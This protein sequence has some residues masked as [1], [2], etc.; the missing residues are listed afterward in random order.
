VS[1]AQ[2]GG[3]E[4]HEFVARA[5]NIGKATEAQGSKRERSERAASQVSACDR[6]N[7]RLRAARRVCTS[8][9]GR[10]CRLTAALT[11]A[12]LPRRICPAITDRR[13]S[14]W[15]RS[16]QRVSRRSNNRCRRQS[17]P[18]S[19]R[20]LGSIAEGEVAKAQTN[21]ARRQSALLIGGAAH[22]LE[23]ERRAQI[24]YITLSP[25][26]PSPSAGGVII[27]VHGMAAP[28]MTDVSSRPCFS[29]SLVR[30]TG[31]LLTASVS[32]SI[33]DATNSGD[34]ERLRARV[35][36]RLPADANWHGRR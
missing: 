9:P 31:D 8:K 13:R 33:I 17:A 1:D 7:M 27:G 24:K 19:N 5:R 18:D 26:G 11:I 22:R 15:R 32:I 2:Q 28:T 34:P 12:S 36:R 4:P 35:L 23:M 3:C 20:I 16:C 30:V 6:P 10:M 14:P 29:G 25:R 21:Q